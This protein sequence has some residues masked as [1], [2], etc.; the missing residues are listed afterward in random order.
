MDVF[1]QVKARLVMLLRR[2]KTSEPVSLKGGRTENRLKF[3]EEKIL[4]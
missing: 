2:I 3:S 4:F 1:G